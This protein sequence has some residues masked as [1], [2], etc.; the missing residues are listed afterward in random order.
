MLATL[1]PPREAI[2]TRHHGSIVS[3]GAVPAITDQNRKW[4]VVIAMSGVMI[5]LTVDFFGITVALP[6]SAKT[7]TRPRRRCCGP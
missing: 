6:A 2:V 7:S 3:S 1:G 5:L 4:W